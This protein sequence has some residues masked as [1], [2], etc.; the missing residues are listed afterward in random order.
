MADACRAKGIHVIESTLEDV[1]HD[2]FEA[3]DVA[4]CFEVIEHV[5]EPINFLSGVSRML[6]PGG[7][8]MF[9][10]PNGKGFDTL[11]L[12]GASPSVDTEHVNLF[13]PQ[14]IV[15]L[16]NRAGFD[17]IC[18]ETPGQLDVELVRRAVLEN[19][20][21]L[22]EDPF[23]RTLLLEKFDTMGADFQHF[24]VEHKLSGN[25]RVI[26]RKNAHLS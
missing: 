24:L 20:A 11:M 2:F 21:N 5:F 12:Q 6:K 13:N 18:T 10:C 14:S 7:L 26:A 25:M 4:V 23:W 17:V 19:K 16:L 22:T 9:T 8:F 15:M 3:A 1:T